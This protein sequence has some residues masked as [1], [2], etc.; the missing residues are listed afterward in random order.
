M[1]GGGRA[2]KQQSPSRL[3][4][5]ALTRVKSGCVLIWGHCG[6]FQRGLPLQLPLLTIWGVL[7]PSDWVGL[8]ELGDRRW[9]GKQ[10]CGDQRPVCRNSQRE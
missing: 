2:E 5:S 6:T 3:Q 4:V 7:S 8:Q 10:G 1:K 9:G